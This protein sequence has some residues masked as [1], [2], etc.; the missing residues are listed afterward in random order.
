[1]NYPDGMT[2]RPITAWPRAHT[3]ERRRAQ[4]SAPWAAT[5]D[6]LDRELYYLGK[7]NRRA[8]SVLQIAMREQDFRL[9]G[10]PRANAVP[11]HPGVI[12]SIESVKGPLS[13]PCDTF[14]RWQDN[15]RAI[16]LSLEALRKIDRY[17]T[18]P[19]DEQYVGW[20]ALPQQ[21]SAAAFTVEAAEDFLRDLATVDGGGLDLGTL[22]Q[23]YRR[24]RAAAHPDRRAGS[25]TQ[26]D[27]VEDAAAVLRNSGRLP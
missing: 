4:F 23:V 14:D 19:S 20:K 11:A 24:A 22:Q 16:A 17:G 10:M 5:L 12:L 6:L 21:V 18:T 7:G 8:D 13:F 3:V 27:L 15:L 25:R 9:D 26:W 1:M 2:L